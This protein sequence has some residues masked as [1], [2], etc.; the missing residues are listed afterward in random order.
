MTSTAIAE[1]SPDLKKIYYKKVRQYTSS[2]N[3]LRRFLI[4]LL[5]IWMTVAVLLPVYQLIDRSMHAEVK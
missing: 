4:F 2:E 1:N 5:V 3:W